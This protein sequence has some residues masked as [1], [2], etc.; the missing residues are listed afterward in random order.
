MTKRRTRAAPIMNLHDHHQGPALGDRSEGDLA[1]ALKDVRSST[2]AADARAEQPDLSASTGDRRRTA[3]RTERR[4][5]ARLSRALDSRPGRIFMHCPALSICPLLPL[6]GTE[7]Q[8]PFRIDCLLC[9]VV[10][11]GAPGLCIP[12]DLPPSI[13]GLEPVGARSDGSMDNRMTHI[14]LKLSSCAVGCTSAQ[15]LQ[16]DSLRRSRVFCGLSLAG[17]RRWRY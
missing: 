15:W 8:L 11:R 16:G 7:H 14:R 10:L 6:I 9:V 2:D 1:E 12:A 3:I 17:S 13:L 5:R 4:D